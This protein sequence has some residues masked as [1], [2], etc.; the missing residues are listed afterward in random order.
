MLQERTCTVPKTKALFFP[1]I[2][3]VGWGPEDCTPGATPAE[4]IG[5]LQG[6]LR[7]YY[8]VVELV[9]EL[10]GK[11]C[12]NQNLLMRGQSPAF[13]LRI[14]EQSYLVELGLLAGDRFPAIADGFWVMLPPLS[15]G[16]HVLEIK[17]ARWL[18]TAEG[19]C[20][21]NGNVT[22]CRARGFTTLVRYNLTVEKSGGR[23]R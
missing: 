5:E 19:S 11:A 3:V 9:C 21:V 12:S 2:N 22:E 10:D 14:P 18:P 8:N 4:C 20:T 17:G 15:P 7:T 6:F 13:T 23:V 1:L 16:E